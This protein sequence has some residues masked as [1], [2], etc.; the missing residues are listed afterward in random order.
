MTPPKN[1]SVD[2]RH[3]A[4]AKSAS[5]AD[6]GGVTRLTRRRANRIGLRMAALIAL[7]S[8]LGACSADLSLNNLTLAPKPEPL[9]RRADGSAQAWARTNFERPV[10][11]ADLVGSEGQCVGSEQAPAE[12]GAAAD[13][14]QA[15]APMLGGISLQMTECDVVRRA[16][17]VE[18]I[19]LG[20]N[21]RGE[22]SLVLTYLKGAAPGLY[23]FAGGRL[24]SIER[25]PGA[26]AAP[27]KSPKATTG[28]K[29]PA[30][31]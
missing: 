30:G 21:E 14:A 9:S 13:Q 1:L 26:P 25:V 23:R 27:E 12:S 19:E 24:V 18:K 28:S 11:A 20:A 31:S 8:M 29:K 10:T 6:N 7:A 4:G 3:G 17:P 15:A 22:R 16:G 2:Q 5:D